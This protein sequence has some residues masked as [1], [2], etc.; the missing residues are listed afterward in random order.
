MLWS[1]DS[2]EKLVT[3]GAQLHEPPMSCIIDAYIT[4]ETTA[5]Y[6][7]VCCLNNT[8]ILLI[9][10]YR[11]VQVVTRP[12]Q[13]CLEGCSKVVTKVVTTVFQ[14][15]YIYETVYR[16]KQPCCWHVQPCHKIVTVH[17]VVTSKQ[18]LY[19]IYISSTMIIEEFVRSS[20]IIL[21]SYSV[22]H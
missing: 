19:I 12:R 16:L 2:E 15:V 9:Y 14:P 17:K 21:Y 5:I 20:Y 6:C 4:I 7:L 8:A 3:L 11:N 10:P 13:P 22:F 18:D 1:S